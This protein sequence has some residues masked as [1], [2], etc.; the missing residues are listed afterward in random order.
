MRYFTLENSDYILNEANERVARELDIT[1]QEVLFHEIAGLGF[2]EETSFRRVGDIWWLDSVN[3][4]QGEITGKI[5][6]TEYGDTTPYQKYVSFRNFIEK[7]PLVLKYYPHGIESGAVFRRRVRVTTLGKTEY[8][9]YGVLDCEITFTPYT[10]WY[11]TVTVTNANS[12]IE[13][14]DSGWIWDTP[15]AFEPF[16][17]TVEGQTSYYIIDDNGARVSALKTKFGAEPTQRVSFPTVIGNNRN[18][19]KLTIEGPAV[20][21]SWSLY[22]ND[23]LA[24]TGGFATD[25]TL[26]DDQYL[27]VD[28]TNGQYTMTVYSRNDGL[29]V[30]VYQNR[31]FDKVCFLSLK[32]GQNAIVV[33]DDESSPIKFSAEGHIYHATV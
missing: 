12:F 21:P 24:E 5:L 7:T 3:Y 20:N 8:T 25:L 23:S 2:T 14:D 11:E 18:P 29:A 9:E 27:I 26:T 6:F 16:E 17:E 32:D 15:V 10:P 31:D 28:N 4:A 19:I 30:D 22:N 1:T 33:S 13:D